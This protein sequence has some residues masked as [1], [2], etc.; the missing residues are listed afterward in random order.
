MHN[1]S[2]ELTLLFLRFKNDNVDKECRFIAKIN[3]GIN[4]VRLKDDFEKIDPTIKSIR[5]NGETKTVSF[6]SKISCLQSFINL[7]YITYVEKASIMYV[8]E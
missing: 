1:C 5:Y 6:L 3:S 7:G 8:I 2:P 4:E